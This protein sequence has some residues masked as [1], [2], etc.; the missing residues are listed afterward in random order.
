MSGVTQAVGG[1]RVGCSLIGVSD[2]RELV[3]S[4][5][6]VAAFRKSG[7]VFAPQHTRGDKRT[8]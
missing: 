4:L 8:T 6:A 2:A 7:S 3:H 1:K 5:D